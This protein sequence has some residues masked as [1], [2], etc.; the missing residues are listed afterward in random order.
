MLC[1]VT[2][3]QLTLY[4]HHLTPLKV[5]AA[6]IRPQINTINERRELYNKRYYN[7]VNRLNAHPNVHVVT[8]NSH[9]AEIEQFLAEK[10]VAVAAVHSVKREGSSKAE[11]ICD[12]GI[13]PPGEMAIFVD[14][15][16]HEHVEPRLRS[17]P[18]LYRVLFVR[19]L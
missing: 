18:G 13:V 15:D 12:G 5:T 16:I 8:R 11:V 2:S 1:C 9:R 14:D 3:K 6:I 10:H 4:C 7:L 17:H 19:G